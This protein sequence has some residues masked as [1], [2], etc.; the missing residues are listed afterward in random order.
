MAFDHTSI[1]N[2][3]AAP[4]VYIM[5]N[6]AGVVLYVGKAKNL[7][8]RVKQYFVPGRDGREMVPHLVAKVDAIE[9]IV[10][11]SE[12]EALLL[13]NTLIKQHRPHFNALLK[14]DKTYISLKVNTKHEWPMVRLVRYSGKPKA[15]G[16]YFGPYTGAYS[17][18]QTLELLQKLFPLRQCS[19]QE[20]ASRTR[21]C[22]L[23][24]MKRCIAPC[25]GRCSHEEYGDFV[26]QTI[27]FLRGQNTEV[28]KELKR[29]MEL[30]S[31]SLDF[32]RAAHF[33]QTIRAIEK[34][35]EAQH[36]DHLRGGDADAYGIFR[37]GE[38]VALSQLLMRSGKVVGNKNYAFSDLAQEDHELLESFLLQQYESAD[39]IPREILVPVRLE[40]AAAIEEI[41]SGRKGQNVLVHHPQRGD[42]RAL[43]EMAIANAQ[44]SFRKER[45]AKV[46]REKI[47]LELEESLRLTRYP[48]RI[49]CLDN[50]NLSG[51]EPVS[52]LVAFTEGEKDT[53]R[54]RLY[55][56]K[57]AVASDDYAAMSEVLTRRYRRAKEEDHLPDLLIVDGG[58]GQLNLAVKI[59]S[60]LDISTVDIIGVAKEQGR[61]DRGVTSEQ[62]FVPH[63]RDPI[64]L[65][66][67]SPIL[68][69]LQRIRDEAHRFVIAFQ[70]KRR[71]KQT[72][73]T[74]L[75]QIEGIGPAKRRTLLRHFGSVRALRAADEVAIRNVKGLSEA[76]VQSLLKFIQS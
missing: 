56:L 70:R 58:K 9:T 41:L 62:I 7:R 36:V 17:A 23:Y 74:E 44:A 33:L 40:G 31:D 18:R 37:E 46:L 64:L 2:F 24:D 67:T 11:T 14:D 12:K 73:T 16:L 22:I 61:H 49:E 35:V 54:Y 27:K 65:K 53:K 55:K 30:A 66:S 15:D 19:D 60:D 52:A 72:I 48:R 76:N 4:G 51:S 47:L 1:Q 71:T 45:D 57:P 34:T 28:L 39:G 59:L 21:P 38:E 13:E 20:L 43:V 5:K 10:V 6:R 8:V 42:K 3:P 75:D 25:V 50:S 63:A 29:Q 68:F 32:E 26:Q 69:L